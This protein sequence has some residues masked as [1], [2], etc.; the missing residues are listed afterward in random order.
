MLAKITIDI[1]VT[2]PQQSFN[3]YKW[4]HGVIPNTDSGQTERNQSF[5]LFSIPRS[6]SVEVLDEPGFVRQCRRQEQW[7]WRGGGG[8]S[9][10]ACSVSG[11]TRREVWVRSGAESQ[12][13]MD[14]I[15]FQQIFRYT[16]LTSADCVYNRDIQSPSFVL[17]R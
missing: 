8:C 16:Y 4:G 12:T 7:L 17:T 10:F 1:C 11:K 6:Q 14:P 15:T 3:F 13:E 9:L 2:M 5:I